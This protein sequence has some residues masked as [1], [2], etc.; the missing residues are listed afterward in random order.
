MSSLTTNEVMKR[1]NI[2]RSSL[3]RRIREGEF[4]G[5]VFKPAGLSD[6]RFDADALDALVEKWKQQ[7][8]EVTR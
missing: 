4:A 8:Q 1:L 7:Q 2:S 3:N 5:V 6:F